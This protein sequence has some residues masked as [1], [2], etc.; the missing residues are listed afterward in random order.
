MG[1]NE[2]VDLVFKRLLQ[3][4]FQVIEIV[5]IINTRTLMLNRFP[6][7]EEAQEVQPPMLEAAEMLIGFIQREW[8]PDEGDLPFL[9]QA[10]GQVGIAGW[11]R[12]DLAVAA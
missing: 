8:P 9:V 3:H 2:Q 12:R 6:R 11:V 7:H 4:R 10:V 1:I 5:V